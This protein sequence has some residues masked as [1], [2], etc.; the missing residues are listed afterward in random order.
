MRCVRILVADN[1]EIERLGIRSIL[2]TH[3][4]HEVCGEAGDS[5]QL[6]KKVEELKPDLVLAELVM[7][8][9]N[10]AVKEIFHRVPEQKILGLTRCE[11]EA[12]AETALRLGVRGI[13]L[14]SD[15]SSDLTAAVRTVTD[16]GLYLTRQVSEMLLEGFLRGNCSHGDVRYSKLLTPRESEVVKA[17]ACG[18][19]NRQMSHAFDVAVKTIESHRSG[20][21][22]KLHLHSTAEL[23]LYALR[24][25]MLPVSPSDTSEDQALAAGRH[26]RA[27]PVYEASGVAYTAH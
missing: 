14:K 13:L 5:Q 23:V 10:D 15:P 24:N 17:I 12:L 4:G 22:R 20:I 27:E 18:M 19:S 11:S 7:L 6:I 8:G 16:G 1:H 2:D 3:P 9:L 26:D 25:A 21:M